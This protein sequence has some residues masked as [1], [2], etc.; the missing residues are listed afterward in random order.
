MIPY[1]LFLEI[2][3]QKLILMDFRIA[4]LTDIKQMQVVRHLVKENMLSNP[5]LVTD[6]DV[7][8][9]I[10]MRGRGWVCETDGKVTGFAI[11]DLQN[12]SVWALFVDPEHAERGAGKELHRLMLNW[13]FKQTKDNIV[14]G[15]SPG[16]RAERFYAFQGW[17][18]IGSYSNGEIKF[19]LSYHDW[20]GNGFNR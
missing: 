17:K 7:A 4:E 19:E 18:N 13:Y 16:T 1:R 20:I 6:K 10:T 2:A 11:V 9:Y 14:L 5:D 15:T 3:S 12:K 8:E